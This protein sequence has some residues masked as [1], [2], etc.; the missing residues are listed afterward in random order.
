[1][2]SSGPRCGLE[3]PERE[4]KPNQ[5]FAAT[6]KTQPSRQDRQLRVSRPM[7][8]PLGRRVDLSTGAPRSP[9]RGE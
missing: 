6:S 7:S 4:M 8:H 1:M 5:L 9:Y 2:G 3:A